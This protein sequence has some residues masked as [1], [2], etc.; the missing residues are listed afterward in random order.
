MSHLCHLGLLTFPHVGGTISFEH[1]WGCSYAAKRPS[2]ATVDEH[3]CRG[4]LAP[5]GGEFFCQKGG[6]KDGELRRSRGDILDIKPDLS[7]DTAW[8]E[9]LG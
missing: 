6:R 2:R 4:C 3:A 9:V 7:G 1:P 5:E 8:K